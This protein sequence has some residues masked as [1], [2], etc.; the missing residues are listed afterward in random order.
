MCNWVTNSTMYVNKN[1]SCIKSEKNVYI[2]NVFLRE[3][4]ARKVHL[5]HYSSMVNLDNSLKV[6][7]IKSNEVS[8]VVLLYISRYTH[9]GA[10]N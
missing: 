10:F 5:P 7:G 6:V 1:K 4:K 2:C 8:I 9:S 3:R